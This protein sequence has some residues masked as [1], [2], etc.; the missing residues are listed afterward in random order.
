MW[1]K[2]I[3]ITDEAGSCSN[4]LVNMMMLSCVAG[5]VVCLRQCRRNA[6]QYCGIVASVSNAAGVYRYYTGLGLQLPVLLSAASS[7]A[8]GTY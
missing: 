3:L 4:V 5:A 2:R 8:A 1:R 6:V 7:A